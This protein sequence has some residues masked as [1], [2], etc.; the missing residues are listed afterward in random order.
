MCSDLGIGLVADRLDENEIKLLTRRHR[1]LEAALRELRYRFLKK[2][3]D[4]EGSDWVLTAHQA[5]DQAE[6]VLFRAARRMDWRSMSGIPAFEGRIIRPLLGVRRSTLSNY[7]VTLGVKPLE[8]RSNQDLSFSR[9]RIRHVVIPALE[10]FFSSEMHGQSIRLSNAALALAKWEQEALNHYMGKGGVD[11][12]HGVLRS[13]LDRVPTL[14]KEGAALNL[15]EKILIHHPKASVL[16]ET[17]RL[18]GGGNS[19]RVRL[20]D[21]QELVVGRDRVILSERMKR[22]R[23]RSIPE[24]RLDVPGKVDIPELGMSLTAIERMHDGRNGFPEGREALLRKSA[25]KLPLMVRTWLPGDRFWPLGMKGPKS[26]SRF[27]RD[28]RIH[29]YD[30]DTIVLVLDREGKIL[31]VAGLEISQSV[32]LAAEE[33]SKAIHLKM[34]KTRTAPQG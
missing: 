11:P 26:L 10:E 22:A 19:G 2:T 29:R 6:T 33:S 23:P 17:T 18:L 14:L 7:C 16:R 25:L 21:E 28:R 15:L 13:D 20:S 1:S 27:L 3:A 8:D 24:R 4:S 34:E 5:D 9:N 32:R 30:R 31:W 12:H